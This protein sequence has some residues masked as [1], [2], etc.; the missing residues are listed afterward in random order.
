MHLVW[1]KRDLRLNDHRPL[2]AAADAARSTGHKVACVYVYEPDYWRLRDTDV[3]HLT[4]INAS[5]RELRQSLRRVGGELI[6]RTGEVTEVF[7][8]LHREHP[9][10][11]VHSHE[12]TGN[13][14]TYD[15]DLALARWCRGHQIPWTEE[16]QNGV[17]RRL[18]TRDGWAKR[19]NA[20]MTEPLTPSPSSIPDAGIKPL[21][22]IATPKSLGLPNNANAEYQQPGGVTKGTE[23][24]QTFL[25][26]RGETYHKSMSSP[27]T[28]FDQCSRLSPHIAYGNLSMRQIYQSVAARR[29]EL[30]Q[31]KKDQG[32]ESTG[33]WLGALNAYAA[34][35]RWHCHFMQKLED[36]P[37]LEWE[38]MN[39]SYDTL[40]DPE[41]D[42]ERFNAWIEGRTGYPMVDACMRCVAVT[43]YLNFR[44]RAMIVSFS[45]YHLWLHWYEP[46]IYL[47][48]VFTD[49]EPGIHFPQHQMQS[50][51]T[52]I[53]TARIY[54]PIK[55]VTDQDPTGKFIR[56]WVP[57]LRRIPDKY[58]P[59][60]ERMPIEVQ[61]QS[62]CVIDRDYPPPIV[63]H[64]TA[65]AAA[66]ERIRA[67]RRQDD[68][69]AESEAVLKKHGSRKRPPNRG[70]NKP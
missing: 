61:Q 6:L 30:R 44:M 35:L 70:P 15:R 52:G 39:R 9:I 55:Q 65:Y 40:R 22:R 56:R 57:E 45:S 62:G 28:A 17:I 13:H 27:V 47:A 42:P 46:A 26:H 63:D 25:D 29:D 54:S 69:R 23:L 37:T 20:R 3:R 48:R 33:T 32:T 50:G 1:F 16:V 59:Q 60:P 41:P 66:R 8:A 10:A 11:S 38:N 64:K 34:R 36:Q 68:T 12:E 53:N 43:G 2:A 51:T 19:W 24:L 14:W 7:N 67:I 58:L 21:G 4:F 5:L 18:K 31:Q 49:Y